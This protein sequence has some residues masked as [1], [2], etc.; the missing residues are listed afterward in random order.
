MNYE[1]KDLKKRLVFELKRKI[2]HILLGVLIIYFLR[3]N[4]IDD[5]TL[6]VVLVCALFVSISSK[7]LYIPIWDQLIEKFDRPE[8]KKTF[9]GRGLIYFIAG[10]LLSI[11]LFPQDIA[12]A[13]IMIVTIGD[14]VSCIFG[15]SY[16]LLTKKNGNKKEIFG[17]F[18][19]LLL[20][21]AFA[22]MFV[23]FKEALLA[24]AIALFAELAEIRLNKQQI[25]D[26]LVVP[27]IAGTT[28]LLMRK[29]LP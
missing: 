12:F 6:F 3:N 17:T 1:E 2:I 25:D 29:F 5:F 7:F 21:V 4:I 24:S 11:K 23:G 19:A 9:P 22:M 18:S 27:L 28:I 10:A 14:S 16:K 15:M 26:N 8:F 13:S 20:S